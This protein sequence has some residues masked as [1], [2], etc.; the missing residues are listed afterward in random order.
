MREFS[1]EEL[2]NLL[3]NKVKQLKKEKEESQRLNEK[4]QDTVAKLEETAAQLE[5]TQDALKRERDNLKR[6]V[7]RKTAELLKREK[8]SAIGELSARVAHDMRNPLSI[9]KNSIELIKVNQK[10]FDPQSKAHWARIERAI[11]RMSHQ[12]ED[13]L[14]YVKPISIKKRHTK[15]SAILAEAI[16]RVSISEK[17]RIIL[18]KSDIEIPC[19]SERLESVFVNLIMNAA[20]AIGDRHGTIYV[21]FRD[22]P[23]TVTIVVKDTGPGIPPNLISKIFD[24]LFTTRQIG[25]GLGLPSC[26]NIVEMHGGSIDVSS[27]GRGATFLIRLP[28][29]TEWDNLSKLADKEKLTDYITSVSK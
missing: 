20:Q 29:K 19:D 11:Y 22:D 3:I 25:T 6:E 10:Y 21:S 15:L 17:I 27:K 16:D 8:L 23:D 1:N 26:K 5:E 28:K 2:S 9:I 13:V 14:D 18:P 12:V 4:L 24:P 7:E